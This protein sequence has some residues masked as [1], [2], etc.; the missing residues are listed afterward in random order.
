MRMLLPALL[1]LS[2]AE[3][4][5]Q[6]YPGPPIVVIVQPATAGAGGAP[7][8]PSA[9]APAASA[10]MSTTAGASSGGAATLPQGGA[11]GGEAPTMPSAGMLNGGAAGSPSSAGMSSGGGG[12]GDA[13][14]P[15]VKPHCYTQAE[16]AGPGHTFTYRPTHSPPPKPRSNCLYYDSTCYPAGLYT[17]PSEVPDE[18]W[19]V[20]APM[21]F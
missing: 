16:C 20:D 17:D 12:G 11:G 8:L 19:T 9:G 14:A 3:T 15:P 10:G 6:I 5:G 2:C 4:P 21:C 13:G 18:C 7:T 1:L